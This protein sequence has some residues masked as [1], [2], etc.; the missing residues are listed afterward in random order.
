MLNLHHITG[1]P[2]H[3]EDL[4]MHVLLVPVTTI[5]RFLIHLSFNVPL[6]Y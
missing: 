1:C 2:T 6:V 3:T 4:R 5:H